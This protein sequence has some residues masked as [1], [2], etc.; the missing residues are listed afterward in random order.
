M[1]VV[2]LP[3]AGDT[4]FPSVRRTGPNT[5]LVANYTSPLADPDRPW[6]VGQTST[7]GTQI[8]LL[9]LTFTPREVRR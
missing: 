7:E 2:D 6:I 5:F 4:A 9:T 8:Y 1:H 3:G